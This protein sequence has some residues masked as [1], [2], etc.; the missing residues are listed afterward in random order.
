MMEYSTRF[1]NAYYAAK[2]GNFDLAEYMI[3]EMKEI[4]EVGEATRPSRVAMLKA[5]EK[6]SLDKLDAAAKAKNWSQ[7]QSLTPQVITACNGCH[8][9]VGMGYITYQ[10]PA[11]P[12]APL[13]M[14]K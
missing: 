11:S 4:Q 10:L 14:S 8:S 7:Y 6:N 2:G 5:F 3:K 1:T 12:P 13:K 9:A